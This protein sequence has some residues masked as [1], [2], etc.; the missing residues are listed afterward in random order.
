MKFK[1]MREKMLEHFQ[2]MMDHANIIF[3]V[4]ADKDKM[5]ELYLENFPQG[6]N[7][8]YNSRREYDCSAC[9]H[10]IKAA[11]NIVTIQNNEVI[12]IWDFD[13]EDDTFRPSIEALSGYVHSLYIRNVFVTK[14]TTIGTRENHLV[15]EDKSIETFYHFYLQFPRTIV[16]TDNRSVGDIQ[17]SYRS[18]K[19]VFK[20][21]L[22]DISMEAIDTV[23][24]L[25]YSNTL[26]K[27][28]EWKANLESFKVY[29]AEFDSIST[30]YKKDVYAWEK[31]IGAGPVIGKIRN[32][33]IGVLLVDIS[34]DIDLDNAVKKYE[35]IVAPINYKRSNPI[36]SKKTLEDAKNKIIEL[37]YF[38]SLPRRYANLD[39]I[40]INN[41]LFSNKDSAKRMNGG[42]DIF[43]SM[44]RDI[45]INPKKLSRVEEISAD[46]FV[47]NVLPFAK[48]IEVLVENKHEKNFVSMIAPVNKDAKTMFKWNNG[49][50]WAYT[51]NITDS[52]IK[53]NVQS[54]GG[55]VNGVLRFSIQWNESGTDN[56]DLDAHC[57]EPTGFEIYFRT[58]KAPSRSRLLGQLDV[59]IINPFDQC[60]GKAAVENITYPKKEFLIPGNYKFFVN[61]YTIR[62]SK[63]FRAEIEFDGEIHQFEYNRPVNEDVTVAIVTLNR[64]GVFSIKPYLVDS[65]NSRTIWGVNV[66]QFV[67]VSVI[68]YSPNYFDKQE[69]IGHRHMFFFLK[70]C[71][72][73]EKPNGF[74]NEYLKNDLMEFRKV[75]EALGSKC[76]VEDTEDQLS[77]I[78]FSMTKRADVIVKV[79]G[80]TE[81][82]MKIKF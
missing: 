22:N 62:N 52:D 68:S 56:S 51:G 43:E 70:G 6:T 53:R 11:G 25:I 28:E 50:C 38:D 64:D 26:Y 36:Y 10:F 72:N 35:E 12:S 45:V 48:E 82:T 75:F 71:V 5:W 58:A 7:E 47:T 37:G 40:T 73:P 67:P 63:G 79:K 39:D 59:D 9:R 14:L 16:S 60:G 61:P 54:Y 42:N 8:I 17:D 23:L 29:K 69:G 77:G 44:E 19:E 78:G 65:I 32:H 31:S 74:F 57:L 4:D 2:Y 41:V 46:N 27:G 49:L 66:N 33:S 81:R 1:T 80:E 24:E 13:P 18:T 76:H 55:D 15:H 21:S 30:D 34:N 20:R 3:E